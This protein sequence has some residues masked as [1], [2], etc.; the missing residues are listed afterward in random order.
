MLSRVEDLL[1]WVI[2]GKLWHYA[3]VRGFQDIVTSKAIFAT[4]VRFLNDYKEFIHAREIA[5]EVVAE[6]PEFGS[7][8]FPARIYLEQAVNLSFSTGLHPSR[9]QV[10]VAS[11]STAE[12]QLSQWRGYSQ[13]SSG[14]SLAF[15]LGA[16][17]PPTGTDT[18][19]CLPH[20][21]TIWRRRKRFCGM[22]LTTS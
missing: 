10:F 18:L 12:D 3:S 9:L 22:L 20:V 2:P 6:T 4:D 11:F 15:Q 7:H 1:N 5:K 14:V 13:G 8:F 21:C 19:V 17:R 16:F